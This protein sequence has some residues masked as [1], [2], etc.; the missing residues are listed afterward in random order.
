MRRHFGVWA[1]VVL[2]GGLLGGA[3]PSCAD[4]PPGKPVAAPVAV[5]VPMEL[6]RTRHALVSVKVNGAGPF[7]L[8]FDTG[9]PL[10]FI[11]GR[12]ALKA[13]LI[14]PERAKQPSFFGMRGQFAVKTLAVGAVELGNFNLLVM[15]HPVIDVLS[16]YEGEI[17]GIIGYSFFSRYRTVLDY[18]AGKMT[19]TPVDYQPQ[20]VMSGLVTRLFTAAPQRKVLGSPALWGLEVDRPD[21]H[22]GMRITRIYPGGAAAAAGLKVG[23]RITTLDGWWTDSLEDLH[24]AA[25]QVAPGQLAELRVVRR[26]KELAVRVRPR[27]GL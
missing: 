21:D 19:L 25:G 11:S 10:T 26:G 2:A 17:D 14:T 9:S 23:D 1:A 24:Q 20:D 27:G 3:R 7:R 15:D 16:R 12:A 6:T 5:S 8:V 18:E 22:P 4:E 13:G